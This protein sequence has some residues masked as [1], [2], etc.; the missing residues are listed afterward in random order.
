MFAAPP[1]QTLEWNDD[2]VLGAQRF[3]RR[4][5][6][7]VRGYRARLEHAAPVGVSDGDPELKRL[8]GT[9]HEL[10]ARADR[11]YRRHQFNTVIAACMEL[12]NALERFPWRAGDRRHDPRDGGGGG[13]ASGTA[14]ENA[15]LREG[16]VILIKLLAPI[17]PH[18]AH[19]LWRQTGEAGEL[20]DAPWPRADAQA[21]V[22]DRV[23]MVVQVNGRVRGQIE[24]PAGADEAAIRAAALADEAVRRHAGTAEPAKVIVVPGR[25]VNVV[26]A[27]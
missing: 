25:L 27:V 23:R 13:A 10:L 18:I 11:D 6:A 21:L 9:V 5:W 2:A 22:R 26:V 3:L 17:V 7:L 1:E 4:L 15:V 14:A 19:A 16:V 12:A 8:R 20:L 24:V